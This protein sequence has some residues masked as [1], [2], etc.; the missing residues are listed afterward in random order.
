ML[1]LRKEILDDRHP[2]TVEAISKLA[3]TYYRQKRYE[4]D[5][6]L[7]MQVLALRKEILGNRHPDTL[8]AMHDLA[9]IWYSRGQYSKAVASMTECFQLQSDILGIDHPDTQ[10]TLIRLQDWEKEGQKT[11]PVRSCGWH[12]P[13]M[14]SACCL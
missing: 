4:E 13:S 10:E 3:I 7:S 14:L 5:E 11:K 2:D 12:L 6:N 9:I 1:A 8:D